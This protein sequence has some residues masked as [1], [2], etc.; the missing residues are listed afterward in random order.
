MSTIIKYINLILAVVIIIITFSIV[1]Y[2][3]FNANFYMYCMDDMTEQRNYLLNR[4]NIIKDKSEY[5]KEQQIAIDKT[6]KHLISIKSSF[7]QQ[8]YEQRFAEIKQCL[9]E[10]NTNLNSETRMLS[11]LNC[12]LQNNDF[13]LETYKSVVQKR[14][15]SDE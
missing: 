13:N 1:V 3:I 6:M 7:T 9:M 11:I 15:L 12:K 4:I 14:S 8:Q 2:I 5:F 10:T